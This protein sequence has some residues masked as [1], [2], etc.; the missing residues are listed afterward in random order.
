M[1]AGA[2]QSSAA[3]KNTALRTGLPSSLVLSCLVLF[4]TL[5]WKCRL[6][7]SRAGIRTEQFAYVCS[8]VAI[9]RCHDIVY[10]R[11][12]R[13]KENK[14]TVKCGYTLGKYLGRIDSEC[15]QP[16]QDCD[17]NVNGLRHRLPGPQSL[18]KS[19][20]RM[21]NYKFALLYSPI[22]IFRYVS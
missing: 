1:E 21:G 2:P 18:V 19:F 6:P 4:P 12:A 10:C 8:G 15:F 7:D 22:L 17:S 5:A 14:Y 20:P 9:R 13:W 3:S 11:E 16:G